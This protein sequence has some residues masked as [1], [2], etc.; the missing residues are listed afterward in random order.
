MLRIK[1]GCLDRGLIPSTTDTFISRGFFK[2]HFVVEEAIGSQEVDMTEVNNDKG[3]KDDA[4]NE[5][6]NKEGGNDMDM[7][8]QGLDDGDTSNKDKQDGEV[9]INGIQEMQMHVHHLDEIK[10]GYIHVPL[11][12][13]GTPSSA[14]NLGEKESLVLPLPY[15]NNLMQNDKFLSDYHAD[16]LPCVSASGLPQGTS[17]VAQH[18]GSLQADNSG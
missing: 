18:L 8:P 3:D 12:P 15:V 2:L 16:L 4:P 11:S 7:D 14:Q 10:I 9:N 1:I 5:E 17:A 6:H 13:K